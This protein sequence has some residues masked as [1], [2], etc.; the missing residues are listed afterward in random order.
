MLRFVGNQLARRSWEAV[1]PAKK[2][3]LYHFFLVANRRA[4]SSGLRM[5]S[6]IGCFICVLR[7]LFS[8]VADENVRK[9]A[10]KDQGPTSRPTDIFGGCF[11]CVLRGLFSVCDTAVSDENVRKNDTPN[12]TKELRPNG[13]FAGSFFCVLILRGLLSVVSDENVRKNGNQIPRTYVRVGLMY[14]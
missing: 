1:P 9:M 5:K 3:A 14:G 10:T 7:G 4:L 8:V 6:F 11:F 13:I 12:N 2:R